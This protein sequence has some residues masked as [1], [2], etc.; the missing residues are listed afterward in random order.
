MVAR[1]GIVI[2]LMAAGILIILSVPF[3]MTVTRTQPVEYA[4]VTATSTTITTGVRREILTIE[5]IYSWTKILTSTASITETK[6]LSLVESQTGNQ[7]LP[8][9]LLVAAALVAAFSV[10]IWR[11]HWATGR[12]EK[13]VP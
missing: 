13:N 12:L 4:T 2:L 3:P 8:Y 11:R 9:V 6:F 7:Y 10:K 5:A 1:P